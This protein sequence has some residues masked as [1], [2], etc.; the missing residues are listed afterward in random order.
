M[1]LVYPIKKFPSS[2][3]NTSCPFKRIGVG[4]VY[5]SSFGVI[6]I[7][8]SVCVGG[9][10]HSSFG[11]CWAGKMGKKNNPTP[12]GVRLFFRS[13]RLSGCHCVFDYRVN[14]THCIFLVLSERA[15][16]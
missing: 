3:P 4:V 8:R 11:L 1:T 13:I 16:V 5:Q 9:G 6:A 10:R 14:F 7:R 15:H 12:E 2:T